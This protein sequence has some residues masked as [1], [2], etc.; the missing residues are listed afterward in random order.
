MRSDAPAAE[1]NAAFWSRVFWILVIIHA[2][3]LGAWVGLNHPLDWFKDSPSKPLPL[4][5]FSPA[6][7][8]GESWPTPSVPPVG[9]LLPTLSS[10]PSPP[11]TLG[12]S[13][14]IHRVTTLAVPKPGETSALASAASLVAD[15]DEYDHAIKEVIEKLWTPPKGDPSSPVRLDLHISSGGIVQVGSVKTKSTDVQL[16]RSAT[17]LLD[18]LEQIGKPLPAAMTT[19]YE[20]EVALHAIK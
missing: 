17:E 13:I 7:F 8:L 12:A 9:P 1:G 3:G 19:E 4:R 14:V 6:E 5:W 20:V 15:L 11:V 16:N 10:V 2:I 18:N